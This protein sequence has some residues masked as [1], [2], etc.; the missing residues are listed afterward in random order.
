[1][2]N[3]LVINIDFA[4]ATVKQAIETI[5]KY[6][7]C[8][9]YTLFHGSELIYEK[10]EYLDEE[11]IETFEAKATR[12]FRM[13]TNHG[14]FQLI[15]EPEG[16]PAVKTYFLDSTDLKE[17]SL[18]LFIG[19]ASDKTP[20]EQFMV[21]SNAKQKTFVKKALDPKLV[22]LQAQATCADISDSEEVIEEKKASPKKM[23]DIELCEESDNGVEEIKKHSADGYAY[24]LSRQ[25]SD[26]E[27]N[28]KPTKKLKV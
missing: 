10:A 2:N 3:L 17:P 14:Q 18:E 8:Q 25:L 7:P 24:G 5:L 16:G 12:T 27:T 23:M 26:D 6:Y 22:A 15:L 20:L 1:M 28:G 11:E 4:T 13:M 9:E 21:E 19:Q